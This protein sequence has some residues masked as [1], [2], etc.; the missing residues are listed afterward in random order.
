MEVL[1]V[2]AAQV[3]LPEQVRVG[4][5]GAGVPQPQ[6][7][8]WL[9]AVG[10][11]ADGHLQDRAAHDRQLLVPR[12]AGPA[13]G[14]AEFLVQSRPGADGHGAVLPGL[15]GALEVGGVPSGGVGAGELRAVARRRA[16][17]ARPPGCGVE[18]EDPGG[19]QPDQQLHVMAGQ[20]V[21]E[22]GGVVARVEQDQRGRV[23]GLP[24]PGRGQVFEQSG[25]LADRDVG[26]LLAGP[27]PACLDGIDPGGR[28]PLDANEQAVGPA[29]QPAVPA[30]AADLHHRPLVG[31]LGVGA[32]VR[33]DIDREHQRLARPGRG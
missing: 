1:L 32:R 12:P 33:S 10:Q 3:G 17:L 5:D 4:R 15:C 20:G 31:V 28:T 13:A 6:V 9:A 22:V 7:L 8:G 26:V 11:V 29:G 18:V 23:A 19:T 14:A 2:E 21:S 30:L 24:R 25:D 27:Q 16:H